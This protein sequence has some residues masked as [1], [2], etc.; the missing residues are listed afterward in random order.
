MF[1]MNK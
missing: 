1:R